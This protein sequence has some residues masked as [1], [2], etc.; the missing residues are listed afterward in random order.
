MSFNDDLKLESV[1]NK[2]QYKRRKIYE[3]FKKSQ[4]FSKNGAGSST[5]AVQ[6]KLHQLNWCNFVQPNVI[7]R[8]IVPVGTQN[9]YSYCLA[10]A[11]N[12]QND[13]LPYLT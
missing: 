11:A 5:L 9:T 4:F 2:G 10:L 7:S 8:A 13:L 6:T 1:E 12:V 3:N